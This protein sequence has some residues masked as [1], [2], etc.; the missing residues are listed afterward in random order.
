MLASMHERSNG[1]GAGFSGYGIYPHLPEHF[2]F[3]LMYISPEARARAEEVLDRTFQVELAEP[4]PTRDV[5]AISNPPGLWRYF[6]LPRPEA[7]AT[8]GLSEED[9]AVATVMEINAN[10]DGAYVF[11]SGR[12]MGTFKAVGLP[13]DVAAFYRL[14]EYSGYMW[15]GHGRFPTNT[16]GWWGGAHPFSLLE[17]S[18]VHNGEIS[19]YGTNARYLESKGYLCTLRTDTEVLTYLLDLL[20]RRH[21]LPME[22]AARALAPPFWRELEKLPEGERELMLAIRRVYG[23]ALAN[24][25]FAIVVG[26]QGGMLGLTDRIKLRPLVA[27][28]RGDRLYLASEEAAIRTVEPNPEIVWMPQAGEPV[29][30][31]L[32]PERAP[33]PAA[34]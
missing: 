33:L 20:V 13:A 11:S 17:W 23:A 5:E 15:I 30:G 34:P 26:F 29:L 6:A 9:L 27:A 4:I 16:P 22:L 7:E 10:V 25:P 19:S 31:S 28:R 14:E 21:G 24:G 32:K 2:A 12:N 18:V 8:T 3:H 1:L